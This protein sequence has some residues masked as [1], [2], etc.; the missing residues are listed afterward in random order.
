MN[1]RRK[2]SREDLEHAS[3]IYHT[4]QYAAEALGVAPGS[5]RRLCK[6]HGVETPRQRAKSR[7][8]AQ[9]QAQA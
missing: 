2:L 4:V 8:Q 1:G 5:F 9:A 7:T 3:R 6:E